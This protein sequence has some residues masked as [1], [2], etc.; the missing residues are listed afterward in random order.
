M[1]EGKKKKDESVKSAAKRDHAQSKSFKALRSIVAIVGGIFFGATITLTTVVLFFLFFYSGKAY[2]G[3]AVAGVGVGGKSL[4]ESQKALED[5]LVSKFPASLTL[6]YQDRSWT[7]SMASLSA[8]PD[9]KRSVEN[10]LKYARK[11][12]VVGNL[13]AIVTAATYGINLPLQVFVDGDNVGE[14]VSAIASEIDVPLEEPAITLT[15]ENSPQPVVSVSIGRSGRT[16]DREETARAIKKRLEQPSSE[17]IALPVSDDMVTTTPEQLDQAKLRAQLFLGKTLDIHAGENSTALT[18]KE[19]IHF[20]SVRNGFDKNKISSYSA[21]LAQQ[22]NKPPQD[23]LLQFTGGR[24]TAFR[25]SRDGLTLDEKETVKK[26]I[27]SLSALEA[28]SSSA[29]ALSVPVKLTSPRVTT[30]E[31]NTLGI[32]ERIGIGISYFSHSSAERIHNLTLL[33]SRINGTLVAPGE[34]FSMAKAA[35]D[36]SAATG[37][38]QA[39]I[40]ENGRTVLGDGGGSCQPSTTLFR[41]ILDAGLPVEERHAHAYRVGY[42]EQGGYQPGLDAT[43]FVPSIDLKF[44]NDTPGH[45]LIQTTVDLNNAELQFELYGTKDNRT[46]YRSPVRVWDQSPAPPPLFQDDPTLPKGVVKQVDFAAA[47]AKTAFDYKVTKDGKTIQEQTFYSNFR[48]WQ[49]VFLRGTKE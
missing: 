15:N 46:V 27:D 39:Y 21:S 45:I 19:L 38:K 13:Q 32:K 8:Q 22:V 26:I 11:G 17:P 23:A 29:M 42:Y 16:L 35:G 7:V 28:T 33:S 6:T 37:Y 5:T 30:A 34:I 20:I 2:P 18:G 43:I 47:G 3:V 49:A 31:A 24:V 41:A 4:S 10:A 12:S 9:F 48:P 40:I 14:T 44:K 1:S 25:P 36:I